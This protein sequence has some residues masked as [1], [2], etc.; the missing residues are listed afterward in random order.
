MFSRATPYPEQ[1]TNYLP[2]NQPNYRNQNAS[3]TYW[4]SGTL[5]PAENSRIPESPDVAVL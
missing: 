1:N 2:E 4:I 3:G 5:E